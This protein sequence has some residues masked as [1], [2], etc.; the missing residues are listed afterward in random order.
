MSGGNFHGQSAAIA[1]DNLSI[2]CA[3]V[4]KIT[5]RR[6]S[7]L[8]DPQSSGLPA[9]LINGSGLNSGLMIPQYV[10]ANL[11]TEIKLAAMPV[12]VDTIPT[13]GGQEDVISNGTIAANQARD[14]VYSLMTIVGIEA[15]C[16]VQALELSRR[17]NLG[18]GVVA[19]HT[20]IREAVAPLQND[21]FM[22]PDILAAADLIKS[23]EL[24]RRVE[25]VTGKLQ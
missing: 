10:A 7:R 20:A 2:A 12:S 15:I 14:A 21:R 25:E 16:S 19:A 4:A 24:L 17:D 3:T 1:L 13:S 5:E 11:A 23:G 6:I 22:E 9:F 8:T 18:F